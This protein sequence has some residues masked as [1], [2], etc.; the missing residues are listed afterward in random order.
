[1]HLLDKKKTY[2]I[3]VGPENH[4][5]DY[6]VHNRI[7]RSPETPVADHSNH[8]QNVWWN[9]HQRTFEKVGI[10]LHDRETALRRSYETRLPDALAGAADGDW[11]AGDFLQAFG[12]GEKHVSRDPAIV[13]IGY[14]GPCAPV[15]R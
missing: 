11:Q 7:S 10:E 13:H 2:A 4:S 12:K 1:M 5:D 8:A 6:H 3:V 14:V 15:V 9:G